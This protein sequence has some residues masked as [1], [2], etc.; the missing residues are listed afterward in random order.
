MTNFLF[1]LVVQLLLGYATLQIVQKYL[2]DRN[3]KFLDVDGY[4]LVFGQGLLV[5]GI[6]NNRGISFVLGLTL[7]LC[8]VETLVKKYLLRRQGRY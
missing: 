8:A 7:T 4:V 1:A 2:P 3:G 6:I 5:L